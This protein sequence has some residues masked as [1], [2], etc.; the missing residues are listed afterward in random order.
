MLGKVRWSTHATR[1]SPLLA[2]FLRTRKLAG[3]HDA[4]ESV[5]LKI[6][7]TSR[8]QANP[9]QVLPECPAFATARHLRYA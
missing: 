4:A 2:D 7:S 6:L 8:L 1:S 3:R 9:E 5:A